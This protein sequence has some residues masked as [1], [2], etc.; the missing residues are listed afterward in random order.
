VG[1]I[2]E[3]RPFLDGG[4]G[5]MNNKGLCLFLVA[6]FSTL[7]LSAN[8][9]D[10]VNFSFTAVV[11]EVYDL[12]N[13]LQGAITVGDTC[14]G[15][16]VYDLDVV[17]QIPSNPELGLYLD[18]IEPSRISSYFPDSGLVFETDPANVHLR[19][20]VTNDLSSTLPPYDHVTHNSQDNLFPFSVWDTTSLWIAFHDDSASALPNDDRPAVMNLSA[21]D[22]AHFGITWDLGPEYTSYIFS[23]VTS[24][25]PASPP[26]SAATTVRTGAAASSHPVN[27]LFVLLIP[28]GAVLIFWLARRI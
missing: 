1:Y 3:S 28:L 21:W 20:N 26:W 12:A 7:P 10:P 18:E 22:T 19:T 13:D 16:L 2:F 4:D 25:S 27:C 11:T 23:D 14:T 6:V 24:I 8:A 17:D 5:L 9:A 15:T